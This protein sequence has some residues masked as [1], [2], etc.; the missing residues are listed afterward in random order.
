MSTLNALDSVIAASCED[1]ARVSLMES[2]LNLWNNYY[3]ELLT[4]LFA[5]IDPT[6][7][8]PKIHQQE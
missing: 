7:K 2:F 6:S 4:L 5:R 8:L 3:Q 1:G